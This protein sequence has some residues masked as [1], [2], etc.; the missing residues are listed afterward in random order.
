MWMI[1]QKDEVTG[2]YY[3]NENRQILQSSISCDPSKAIMFRRSNFVED[4]W[5][6]LKD[7]STSYQEGSVLYGG[8]SFGGV[9]A[10]SILNGDGGDVYIRSKSE[11]NC[12]CSDECGDLDRG[13]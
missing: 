10:N 4:P 11:Y 9:H 6:T 8:N 1:M 7:H 12:Y 13:S 2:S 3:S 5:I